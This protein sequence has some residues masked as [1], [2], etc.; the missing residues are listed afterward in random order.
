MKT[1]RPGLLALGLF[2]VAATGG[3]MSAKYLRRV[4]ERLGLASRSP[5]R[6]PFTEAEFVLA[7]II[8]IIDHVEPDDDPS[9]VLAKIQAV[10]D[11]YF[12]TR[13]AHLGD[14]GGGE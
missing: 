1:T 3:I 12:R 2:I 8:A 6:V 11:D 5:R 9:D 10:A 13:D 14:D 7:R 4:L